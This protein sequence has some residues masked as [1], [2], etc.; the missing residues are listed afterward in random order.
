[1]NINKTLILSSFVDNREEVF[2]DRDYDMI[3]EF[4]DFLDQNGWISTDF[5]TVNIQNSVI[6]NRKSIVRNNQL[7]NKIDDRLSK[8]L[9]IIAQMRGVPLDKFMKIIDGVIE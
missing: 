1:M 5:D 8:A 6:V 2:E 7:I 9:K 3:N 4:I